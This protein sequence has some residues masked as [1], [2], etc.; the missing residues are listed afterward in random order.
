MD[1]FEDPSFESRARY[2]Y[3]FLDLRIYFEALLR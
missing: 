1:W 3:F 2:L